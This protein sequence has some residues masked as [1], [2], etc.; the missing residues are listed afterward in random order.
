MVIDIYDGKY[1][2]PGKCGSRYWAKTELSGVWTVP[3][4]YRAD[5]RDFYYRKIRLDWMVVRPPLA[6]LKSALQT[7]IMECFD[8]SESIFRILKKFALLEWG[9][10]HFHPEFCKRTYQIWY[11]TG[12]RLGIVDLKDLTQFLSGLGFDIPYNE[13]EYNF[14][15]HPLYKSKEEVWNKCMELYPDELN[16]LVELAKMD[17]DYYHAL[18]NKDKGMY[19]I[20]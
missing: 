7:E 11:R 3:T 20:L 13:S 5:F 19:K 2:V 8:D 6:H 4:I 1:G 17:T 15:T 14:E 12:F 10:T 9:G 18:L 16:H